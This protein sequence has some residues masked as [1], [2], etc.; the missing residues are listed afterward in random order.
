M[1]KNLPW[2]IFNTTHVPLGPPAFDSNKLSRKQNIPSC[3]L[4]K[5]FYSQN[6]DPAPQLCVRMFFKVICKPK[7]SLIRKSEKTLIKKQN[8]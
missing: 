8:L 7:N 4:L 5:K 2:K 3:D 6:S 1:Y